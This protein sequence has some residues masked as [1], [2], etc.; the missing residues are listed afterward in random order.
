MLRRCPKCRG[1]NIVK[2]EYSRV[3]RPIKGILT[4]PFAC[5]NC[6]FTWPERTKD[7]KN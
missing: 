6:G 7:E 1:F 2:A 5:L 3:Y 4:T